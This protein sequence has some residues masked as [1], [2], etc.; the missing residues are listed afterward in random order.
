MPKPANITQVPAFYESCPVY[1]F[2]LAG[3]AGDYFPIAPMI[4]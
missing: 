3:M 4:A 2:W 1:K